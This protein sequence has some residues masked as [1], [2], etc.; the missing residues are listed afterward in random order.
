M[1]SSTL[2]AQDVLTP[3][4]QHGILWLL[5]AILTVGAIVLWYGL[6]WALVDRVRY[7]ERFHALQDRVHTLELRLGLDG[8]DG[9]RGELQGL[10][11]AIDAM[12]LAS[13]KNYEG[14]VAQLHKWNN[15]LQVKLSLA[16]AKADPLPHR[17]AR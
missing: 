1:Q 12:E 6:R 5:A 3:N 10:R 2:T 8:D 11:D 14:L 13:T 4:E 15:E 16:E 17:R 9:I 7:G